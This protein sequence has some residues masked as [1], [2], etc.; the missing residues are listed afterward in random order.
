MYLPK[1]APYPV[2]SERGERN[3]K[4][5]KVTDNMMTIMLG[6]RGENEHT[7]I[8]FDVSDWMEEYPDAA[9][10]LINQLP[11]SSEEYPV[12]TSQPEDGIVKWTVGGAELSTVG[13]GQCALEAVEG[14]VIAKKHTWRTKILPAM[15]EPGATPE[16]W[17]SWM[18]EFARMVGEAESAIDDAEAWAI[19]TDDTEHPAYEN[20][21]KE[22]AEAAEDAKD[23][24]E[25]AQEA[26]EA[27]QAAA[28]DARDAAQ[29]AGG[30]FH[31]LSANITGLEPGADPTI[32]VTHS[33]GGFYNLS[34][35]IPAGQDGTDGEDGQDGDDGVTFT[36]SVSNE[37]VIS[38]TNDGGKTNP[39]SVNIKG[40]KGD[41]GDPAPASAV[42]PAVEDWLE[43]NF[44]PLTADPP[45]DRSLT[46]PAAAAPA[47]MVGGL[48]SA[49]MYYTPLQYDPN[50]L[51]NL[52]YGGI[53]R[54]TWYT[55]TGEKVNASNRACSEMLEYNP[56]MHELSIDG[57]FSYIVYAGNEKGN[58]LTQ[59][60][61]SG[62]TSSDVKFSLENFQYK[63][64]CIVLSKGGADFAADEDLTDI[65]SVKYYASPLK[66][67]S[68][69]DL[70][71]TT[72]QAFGA[73][74]NGITDDTQAIQDCI[75][76]A[77]DNYISV[78]LYGKYKISDTIVVPGQLTIIGCGKDCVITNTNASVYSILVQGSNV[79]IF[80]FYLSCE[81]GIQISDSTHRTNDVQIE[82]LII[83][84]PVTAFYIPN[85]TGCVTIRDCYCVTKGTSGSAV[86]IGDGDLINNVG[87]NYVYFYNSAFE[88]STK[89]T[90]S[91][92]LDNGFA[93]Y[94]GQYIFFSGCDI[95]GYRVGVNISTAE[96]AISNIY[97]N[98]T[99]FFENR[100]AFIFTPINVHDVIFTDCTFIFKYSGDR[101]GVA[102]G[103]SNL[104]LKSCIYVCSSDLASTVLDLRDLTNVVVDIC[105]A[106]KTNAKKTLSTRN[107]TLLLQKEHGYIPFVTG[108]NAQ[109]I[110]VG[111]GANICP[112]EKPSVMYCDAQTPDEYTVEIQT[113]GTY[114][115]V[116]PA[117]T[118]ERVGFI[119][120]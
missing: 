80:N 60:S 22:H 76:F 9:I 71:Y 72:P 75:D 96:Q 34:F 51:G 83:R 120:Y 56:S 3:V 114:S 59:V 70:P 111:N 90:E 25:T 21:A 20:S 1:Y 63:F 55:P 11:Y 26:A 47:D 101:I 100:D 104:I 6:R 31:G 99:T 95:C 36:P 53:P 79:S 18:T 69:L 89:T 30:D 50:E 113:T 97:F 102:G 43:E 107:T 4:I 93:V 17:E 46:Q 116:I 35:G 10:L 112:M 74:G 105:G 29:L 57:T 64:F 65:F 106:N 39:E 108:E 19:G 28:E 8:W 33:E 16:A 37:G 38:W 42:V 62:W 45:L 32:E 14:N 118:S 66:Y 58:S 91:G 5:I 94:G 44:D 52:K 24:A 117:N 40:P 12:V 109:T 54:K 73:V 85:A 23:S 81:K 84:T 68:K 115:V 13:F 48:K 98:K 88:S 2:Q 119:V 41:T 103:I 77:A 78:H 27:A 7:Q 87:V 110:S 86:I 49:I 15:G 67:I 61:A 92:M 82:K